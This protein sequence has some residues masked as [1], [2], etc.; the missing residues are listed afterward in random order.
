MPHL[1]REE[2]PLFVPPTGIS[3]GVVGDI[4]KIKQTAQGAKVCVKGIQEEAFKH[5]EELVQ[6]HNRALATLSKI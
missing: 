2:G 5:V 4:E 6:V 3:I 1:V